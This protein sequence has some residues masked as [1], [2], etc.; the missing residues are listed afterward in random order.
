MKEFSE[1][2]L[3]S[4]IISFFNTID[5]GAEAASYFTAERFTS[6]LVLELPGVCLM[7]KNKPAST[8]GNQ[9]H[10]HVTGPSRGFFFPLDRIETLSGDDAE[11]MQKIV[12]SRANI[13]FLN[14]LDMST[15]TTL[16]LTDTTT[17]IKIGRTTS[18]GARQVQISKIRSD[19]QDFLDLRN[20]LYLHDLLIM[21]QFANSDKMFA[22]GLP[23]SFYEEMGAPKTGILKPL[24]D[25]M[26]KTLGTALELAESSID[27]SQI[28][29]DDDFLTDSV[30]Q[31][32]VDEADVG[33]IADYTEDY[34]ENETFS[35]STA[36]S[37]ITHRPPVD[38]KK[39]KSVIKHSGYTCIFDKNHETFIKEDGTR[40]MEVH[41]IIP[42]S[43]QRLF[44]KKL[45]TRANLVSVCPTCHRKLH[46]GKKADVDA[47]LEI[48]YKER[49]MAL[50]KSGLTVTID[51]LKSYY[52]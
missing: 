29:E 31:Q 8:S 20:G 41:H 16:G 48:L 37:S 18:K 38:A 25:G 42:V 2:T 5:L 39:G 46:H 36:R 45:D 22:L 40:Y 6:A 12:V 13:A 21:L 3:L 44:A 52:D 23:A 9:S 11:R 50:S 32:L 19:G 43:K 27:P 51:D 10:I 15:Y 34:E 14:R 26:F 4:I 28:I 33:D 35:Q 17:L 47:M 7:A 49:F 1:K 24:G 30:Y